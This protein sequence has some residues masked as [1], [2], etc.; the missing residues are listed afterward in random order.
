KN[1]AYLGFN[2]LYEPERTLTREG[3]TEDE[4]TLGVSTA[5]A[6]R[7]LPQVTLGA[8]SW[9]LRHYSGLGFNSFTGDAVYVGPNLYVQITPKTFMTF[10]WNTQVTGHEVGGTGNLNLTDFARN[11]FKIKASVE[12]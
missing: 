4:S 2:L 12:F 10:A 6:Y 11:R 1:R 9:Y 8:E 3:T 7:V 5:F